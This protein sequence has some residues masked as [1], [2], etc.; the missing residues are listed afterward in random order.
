MREMLRILARRSFAASRMRNFIAVLA[1]ALTAVL[2]TSVTTIGIGTTQSMT[3]AMQMQKGSK[4]DGDFRNMTLEQ[5]EAMGKADF[6]ETAGLRM[7]VAFLSNACHHVI[8]FDVLDETQAELTF[9]MPSHGSVPKAENE[10]VTSDLA[11]QD[12]GVEP[13]IGAE[14]PIMFTAHGKTYQLPMVVSGWYEATSD[15]IS[16]MWSN[17]AFRDAHSEIFQYTY[18]EDREM[19]GTYWSDFTSKSSV[20]LKDKMKDLAVSLGG[21]PENL[22]ADN[23]LPAVVNSTT[24]QTFEF[25]SVAIVSVFVLLF[26]FC[27]YLLIYNVFD[28]AVMQEIRRYGLYRTIGMGKGQLKKLINRQ[29]VWLSCI[30]I[31]LGLVIGF[32]IGKA[33]LPFIMN[34]DASGYKNRPAQVSPSPVI[35]LGGALLAAFTVF[36]STR[37]PVR[38]AAGIPPIEAFRYVE[39]GAGKRRKKKSASGADIPRLAWSNLGRNPRRSAFIIVSLMLCVILLNCVGTISSSLDIEKQVSYMI[40]TDFA[41]TNAASSNLIKGFVSREDKL[42]PQAVRDI[43]NRPG[44]TEGAPVYKNTIEDRNVT[45]DFGHSCTKEIYTNEN[46]GMEFGFDSQYMKFGLGDD[47]R[48][49][50]N[51]YGME[52]C[53]IARMDI[54]QGEKDAHLLY[55]KM[56]RGEGVLV[57]VEVNRVNMRPIEDLDFVDVGQVITVYKDGHPVR[58]LPVLA[59]AAINGDDAEIGYTCNGPTE[60]GGDGLFLYLPDNIYKELYDEPVVYKYAFNVEEEHQGEM[61]EFLEDYTS[62]VDTSVSYLTAQSARENALRT[63]TMIH[64]V[65]GMA[66]TIF[67]FAGVLNLINTLITTILTRR[68]E[69]ATMQS[70]GMTRGQLTKMMVFESVYY[71]LGACLLGLLWA[72]VMNLTLIFGIL[73]SRWEYTFHFTLVP[74]LGV[75]IVL[76]LVSGIVPVLALKV[77]NKGSIVEQLRVAE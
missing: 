19:A 59:K 71:A 57:G 11:L 74:A 2:F 8:E 56:S 34:A 41:I 37:K 64:F 49:I 67:G 63:R 73:N 18:G 77:F 35:F 31:P 9:C 7:P 30:G 4:S 14:V 45:Y 36:L 43:G 38:M 29:A 13:K 47:K 52:E 61:A 48:P 65:G 22:D 10:I 50:C 42:N 27:G 32:L 75:S 39:R 40:R 3:L 25:S 76:L 70:I 54:R 17:T 23:Y 15:Q 1:I 68:H 16:M 58:K 20:G 24:H 33:A 12:L 60:V 66:G 55:E 51:V 26:I 21:D 72:A 69:F 62:N 53:A 6:V 28:I 5:F 46:N 44:I